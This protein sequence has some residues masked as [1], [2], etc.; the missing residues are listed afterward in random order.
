MAK[1]KTQYVNPFTP[2]QDISQF[3]ETAKPQR[4]Q[5]S[6]IWKEIQENIFPYSV[7]ATNE[8]NSTNSLI[9]NEKRESS[10]AENVLA[11][12]TAMATSY[13][14][15][16]TESGLQIQCDDEGVDQE[17]VNKASNMIID[18]LHQ[19]GRKN[20]TL[21][22]SLLPAVQSALCYGNSAIMLEHTPD[23]SD[24][25]ISVL[26]INEI[27]I[28]ANKKTGEI[29]TIFR[30]SYDDERKIN[31]LE[32]W[33]DLSHF[34]PPIPIKINDQTTYPI[35]YRMFHE[36]T[37]VQEKF[38]A[39]MP[40]CYGRLFLPPG[41]IYGY[42]LGQRGLTPV[43]R[44]NVAM[45][46]M[47]KLIERVSLP[48]L[49][50]N[51]G[52]CP[53]PI[54]LGPDAI[55]DIN[56]DMQGVAITPM[57]YATPQGVAAIREA[58]MVLEQEIRTA[59]LEQ[60]LKIPPD[61]L[62][63]MTATAVNLWAA[64]TNSLIAPALN[65]MTSAILHGMA[66]IQLYRLLERGEIF[67][68]EKIKLNNLRFFFLS[69][70]DMM[71]KRVDSNIKKEALADIGPIAQIFPQILQMVKMEELTRDLLEEGGLHKSYL[72]TEKEMRALKRQQQGQAGAQ[73]IEN[74][75]M[76]MATNAPAA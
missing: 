28:V 23:S 14:V 11:N 40:I 72:R 65:G 12:S 1:S 54:D 67:F 20:N 47:I 35:H 38:L 34:Q 69:K 30:E 39:Q 76:Q 17:M 24:P 71:R 4:D 73:N 51:T 29:N 31:R 70:Q 36:K 16:S 64:Q 8:A 43:K 63:K 49:L 66:R 61:T 13:I 50:R 52:M 74:E 53:Q 26:N 3:D 44:Y 41:E 15:P 45:A 9:F 58:L 57:M 60:E 48:P 19:T 2:T 68:D 5:Y 37:F 59:F 6:R 46:T 42:G 10:L 56:P 7:S 32:V 55:N 22:Q 27:Y 18:Q 75:A 21:Y 25:I 62:D 33:R